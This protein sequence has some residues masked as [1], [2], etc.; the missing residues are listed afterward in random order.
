[1]D[2]EKLLALAERYGTPL[3]VFDADEFAARLRLVKEALGERIRLCYSMKANPFLLAC[4]PPEL[5]ALEVCSP[6]EL[7]RN[8]PP[9]KRAP[10]KPAGASGGDAAAEQP[11]GG[12]VEPASAEP[13][14]GGGSVRR[15]R[16]PGLRP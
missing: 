11:A 2:N 5:G 6:G 9:R 4:L 7:T 15:S 12:S 10:R 8:R 1:M 14:S 16:R 13:G 3:Y